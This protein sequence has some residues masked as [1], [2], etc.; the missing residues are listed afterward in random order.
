MMDGVS[1]M[2]PGSN[3]L[4]MAVNVESVSQVKVLTSNYQAE[5]GRSSGLQVAAVTKSGTNRFRGSMYDVERNSDWN[6][7][8][9]VNKLNGD[10]KATTKERDWG[11]SI[12]GPI[13]RA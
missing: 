5:Y 13:G 11:Y 3:R 6:A 12:G 4:M 1:T 8:S 10:P 9:K 7:N 2:E